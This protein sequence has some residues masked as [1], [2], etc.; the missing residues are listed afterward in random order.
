MAKKKSAPQG[1]AVPQPYPRINDPNSRYNGLLDTEA[2][3]QHD[4]KIPVERLTV[5][6]NE[7]IEHANRKSRREVITVPP[8]ATDEERRRIYE[9]EGVELFAYFHSYANDPASTAH[10]MYKK[11]YREVGIEL[12]R[13]KTLQ[14]ERMNSGW[15]YQF[16]SAS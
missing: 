6:I 7:A 4:Y 12:F 10:Q 8:D 15:R 1:S 16:L 9:E 11:N 14:R 5:L 2:L 13:N 3:V